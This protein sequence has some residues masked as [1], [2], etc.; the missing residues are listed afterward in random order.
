MGMQ[1]VPAGLFPATLR[2]F[3]S[4]GICGFR[5]D[6]VLVAVSPAWGSSVCVSS[7]TACFVFLRYHTSPALFTRRWQASWFGSVLR[8]NALLWDCVQQA[9]H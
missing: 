6:S 8:R 9:F 1:C 5:L 3:S 7:D 4:N 2:V